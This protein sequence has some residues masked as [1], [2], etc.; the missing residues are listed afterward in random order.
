MN[1]E[2]LVYRKTT[3]NVAT[4]V[5]IVLPVLLMISGC[6]SLSKVQ[7]LEGDWYEIG[8]VDGESGMESARFDEYVDTCAKYDVVPDFVK[9]SEGRTKGLEIFCTRSNG[10][11]EGREGSVYRNV[12]SGISE[13][14]FLVG[15]SFGHKVYSALET[16]NTLN[17]EIS[18]KAKQ[19]RNWEIQ[20]DEILDLS[21][22]GANERERDAD[23]RNEL[24]DQAADLQS[25]ITEAKAQVKELRDRKAEAMIEYR[26]AVDEANENGF[27]EEATIEF[28]E[29]SDDGKFMG[30]N[31]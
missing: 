3:T 20:G 21:F 30:T 22:A 15:Y 31:P 16:I 29:V 25:D 2:K 7:C 4:F 24:S 13:E 11:S 23:E 6:T 9:Y 12:C 27:P 1:Q 18:E 26:T 10:Y 28:P 19:I 17:S 5:V 14:L 8:L